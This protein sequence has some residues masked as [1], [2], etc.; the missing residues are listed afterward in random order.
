MTAKKDPLWRARDAAWRLY[1]VLVTCR[2]DSLCLLPET[3]E[4][5]IFISGY[6][7]IEPVVTIMTG[8]PFWDWNYPPETP[9]GRAKWRDLPWAPEIK[10]AVYYIVAYEDRHAYLCQ[11]K[12]VL[13]NM[14]AKAAEQ[15]CFEN[16]F[17]GIRTPFSAI[18]GVVLEGSSIM[19]IDPKLHL[20]IYRPK[21]VTWKKT[22]VVR[23]TVSSL[24]KSLCPTMLKPVQVEGENGVVTT[25]VET[26]LED[27]AEPDALG[28]AIG[29]GY[30]AWLRMPLGMDSDR[31][32]LN[33][34]LKLISR[35]NGIALKTSTC[36]FEQI[37][38]GHE[39]ADEHDDVDEGEVVTC[40]D[41]TN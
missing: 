23:C 21:D 41:P 1:N 32:R 24:V 40:D 16:P 33:A 7:Q 18:N 3:D 15:P 4:P 27:M 6:K 20:A 35:A 8:T 14:N 31:W 25:R 5:R 39:R 9:D 37:R 13:E 26:R 22:F 12:H 17:G 36:A 34:G 28:K 38:P 2:N 19:L 29:V 10:S 11:P 30:R